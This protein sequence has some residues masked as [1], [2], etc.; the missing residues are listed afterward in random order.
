MIYL[1]YLIEIRRRAIACL[2]FFSTCFAVC[3]YKAEP[4]TLFLLQ[5]LTHVLPVGRSLIAINLSA[6]LYIPLYTAFNAALLLSFPFIF[7]QFWQFIAPSLFATERKL[8]RLVFITSMAMSVC[9]LAFAYAILLP[10]LFK[11][12]IHIL[13]TSVALMPDTLSALAFTMQTL[14]VFLVIFQI[15]LLNFLLVRWRIISLQS[16]KK[17]RPYFIVLSFIVGMIVTPPD[18]CSQIIVAVPVCVLYELGM[19]LCYLNP[20][21]THK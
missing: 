5:P 15:P 4:L 21:P 18:V 7:T 14:L 10:F 9:G 20:K 8:L 6:S 17:F 11:L 1:P 3:F 16:L 2:I 12:S 13:P 19:I